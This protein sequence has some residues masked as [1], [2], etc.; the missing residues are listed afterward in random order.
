MRKEEW[1]I[2]VEIVPTISLWSAIKMRI[3][4]IKLYDDVPDKDY[5]RTLNRYGKK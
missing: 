4:G 1:S 3:A 2:D 5:F